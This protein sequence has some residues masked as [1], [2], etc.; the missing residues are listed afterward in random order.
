LGLLYVGTVYGVLLGAYFVACRGI[1]SAPR[2]ATLVLVSAV[3]WPIAY[4]GSFAAAGHIPG[5][6]VHHGDAAD[7]AFPLIA[8]GGVLG[9]VALLIPVL[10]L[11]KPLSVSWRAALVKGILGIL[12]SGIAGAIAWQLGPTLGAA[13]WNLLPTASLAEVRREEVYP[14]AAL[15]FVWQPVIALFIGWAT[16]EKRKS[17][18]VQGSEGQL[19]IGAAA[20]QTGGGLGRRAFLLL[21]AGLLILSLTRMVPLRLRQAHRERVVAKKRENRP[22]AVDLP[23][24]QPMS[25]DEALILK[26]VGDCQPGH[27]L[28]RGE[29]V[30]HE[31]GLEDQVVCTSVHSTQ[32]QE[33]RFPSGRSCPGNIS[34]LSFSNILITRG[35]SIS[36][37]FPRQCTSRLTIQ[38]NTPW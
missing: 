5:G 13:L 30:S 7:P 24:E 17:V 18:P 12:L 32:K 8:F 21:L 28:K 4:F 16:S 35:H 3:A 25:E 37:S 31:K 11:F 36:R 1:R 14:M 19:E 2:L 29:I 23:L 6:I 38:N 9:G 10:L 22:A 15:F 33:S 34:R 20:P 27:A 26:Q